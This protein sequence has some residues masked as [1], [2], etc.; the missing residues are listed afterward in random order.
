MVL[1][2]C[3]VVFEPGD[4]ARAGTF[5][6][7]GDDP[8]EWGERAVAV[9]TEPRGGR[10]G[11]RKVTGRRV[12]VDAALPL[13]AALGADAHPSARF[14]AAAVRAALRLAARGRVLPGVSAG[15]A[16]AWRMG[17]FD[18]ADVERLRALAAAM[19]A[20][21]RSIPVDPTA[22]DPVLPDAETLLRALFDAVADTLPR[23]AGAE[24]L[25]GDPRYAAAEPTGTDAEWARQ[26]AA[27]VDAGLRVALR[28]ELRGDPADTPFTAVVRL[29]DLADPTRVADAAALWS[30]REHRFGD[31]AAFEAML[32]VRRAARVWSPLDGLLAAAE[33]VEVE[34]LDEDVAD[35]LGGAEARLAAAGVDIEWPPGLGRDLGARARVRAPGEPP[36]D[37]AAFLRAAPPQAFQWQLTLAGEPLIESEM[38]TVGRS[39]PVVRLRDR[40]VLVEPDLARKA[41][42]P[43]LPPL[44]PWEGLGAALIGSA[45]VEGGLVSV[46]ADGWLGELVDRVADPDGGPEELD[47]PAALTATLRDYQ[48]RGLRWLHRMTALGFGGCLADDM[49][50]GKTITLIALHLRRAEDPAT[51]GPTLVVCPAS[52]LGNWES[53]IARFAPGTPV[54][55][56]HGGSRSLSDMDN[57]FV[58]TTY[59]TMRVE[60]AELAGRHWGLVVADEAQHVKNRLS[61]TAKALRAIPGGARVALTGTPV[62]NNLTELWALLDWTTPGLLGTAGAFR[63]GWSRTIEVDRDR[64]TAD[65]LSRLVR[66][67]L[68]RRRKSDP[69][70]APELPPKIE[71]DHGVELTAEQ[72]ALYERVV[73]EVLAEIRA[74]ATEIARRGLVLKLLVGLKQVCNHPAHYL[75]ET[76]TPARSR[77]EKLQLLDDLVG[78]VLAE[79][80]AV[81]VFT[82]Y[83]R[84]ARLLEQ[85]FADRGVPTRLLHG[86]TPVPRREEMVRRFQSGEVPV[87][88]LSL[89]AAGTGLNLTRADHVVHYDRWWNPAVEAQATDRAHRIGQTKPVQVHRLIT[90]GTLEERIARLL[91]TKRALADAVL[92]GGDAAL[93]ALSDAELLR[94]VELRTP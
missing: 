69:G 73:R 43:A 23:T 50:L 34:L 35:L 15:G 46:V 21:A 87:F 44:P 47:Q 55:R 22:P 38:D 32:A 7:H 63:R 83:V 40:W 12:P 27:G 71:T 79:G 14:H 18:V 82:Q 56:F 26:V 36:A 65:R 39:R 3:A 48:R 86:G 59:G 8:P 81:L 51:A 91:E 4:P 70:I 6:V 31:R 64:R 33:P 11:L 67:F 42:E 37:V 89:K 45:E 74:G 1:G 94:L 17:P 53:E 24:L 92:G 68:L 76:G 30:G 9:L 41:R 13:L 5:L 80:G 93:S 90:R 49:G 52:V 84:M 85:H 88:L 20:S 54:R 58:L 62:E 60:A 10:V 72:V 66:P 77:S 25:T 16:D 57:G 28:L 19:P 29:R 61:G 78:T 75:K 2:R